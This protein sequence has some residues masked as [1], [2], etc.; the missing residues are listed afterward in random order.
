MELEKRLKKV[1]KGT[2]EYQASWIADDNE[3]DNEDSEYEDEESEDEEYAKMQQS[4]DEEI[5]VCH[6][7]KVILL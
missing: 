1:P 3:D 6:P 5:Q 2:S 7:F 4:D